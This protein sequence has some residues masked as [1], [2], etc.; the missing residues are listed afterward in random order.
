MQGRLAGKSA[1][2]VADPSLW[3]IRDG[4][5]SANSLPS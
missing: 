3:R 5:L 4:R 1:G 2:A